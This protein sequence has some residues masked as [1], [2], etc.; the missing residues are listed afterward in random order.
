MFDENSRE[1]IAAVA[2]VKSHDASDGGV[3]E[4]VGES[5]SL[6]V[7]RVVSRYS[8]FISSQLPPANFI[9]IHY[10]YFIGLCLLASLIFWGSSTPARSISYHDSLFLAV[11]AMTLTGLNTVNLSQLN[12]FQQFIL[13]LLTLLGSAI[14]VSIAVVFV[15]MK[16][17]ERRFKTVVEEEKRRQKERGSLRRRLTLRSNRSNS[18]SKRPTDID[19]SNGELRSRHEKV[20][21]PVENE[22][23][24]KDLEI[25]RRASADA[26]QGHFYGP[27]A[28][29]PA[30]TIDT[31]A[32]TRR[33]ET[34]KED[35]YADLPDGI[36]R[37]RG[38]TFAPT[39]TSSKRIA[40]LAR[41]FSMQ[42]VGARHDLPNH[43]IRI[44][45]PDTFLSPVE[46]HQTTIQSAD[47]MHRFWIPGI[48]GRNSHFSNLSFA[49]RERLGGVEY[50][51]LELLIVVVPLYF[52]AWQFLGAIGMGAWVAN[53]GRDLTQ[54]N[55]L[56]PWWVGAFNAVSGF[57]NSGMMLLDAN[58]V[59]F[60]TSRYMLITV[61]LLIL[62]GN[63]CYP[64]FLRLIL[65]TIWSL[66]RFLPETPKVVEYR[67]TLRFLLDHPRRCY[68]NLFPARHTWWLLATL[69]GLNGIDWA[70]FE[71][72]NIGNKAINTNVSAGTRALE[73]LFQALAVRSGGFYVVT[74][75]SL[76]AGLLV[77]YVIMMY[78][79]VY[80]V[81]IS[82]RN[83]N[84][85]E[86]RSLGIYSEE[87]ANPAGNAE[88]AEPP[89][90]ISKKEAVIQGL[91]RR[92]TVQLGAA[93]NSASKPAISET[94]GYFVRQQL[95]GQLAHDLWWVVLAV[96]FIT[97]TET[98][99]YER[100]PVT[101]SVFNIIF[102]VISAYGCVGL[103]V[104]VP[105]AAYSFA[106]D[107]HVLS[108][109]IL[110]AV[111]LRGRHRGLPVA[112]DRAV[113][114]PGDHLTAAEEED[115]L[116]RAEKSQAKAAVNE[117]M[118]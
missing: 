18:V 99:S 27:P 28:K 42:G 57:N 75:S 76:R 13:F 51:T 115:A 85:Y 31:S 110:C 7:P 72:L 23:D 101:F 107:W 3:A 79:S 66:L 41:L 56:D 118:V 16:A 69:V 114:L 4:Q 84:V 95:R 103:S 86:E 74:I 30:L 45:R 78:I 112:I 108:K 88:Q 53:N 22:K 10:A 80:P 60:Q 11:S 105:T 71:V 111:M 2:A 89:T 52:V 6:K 24:I 83:S 38:V 43:P 32:D 54:A 17:F 113:L 64:V 117:K 82:I 59:A 87:P 61:G 14:T 36:R 40:P 81:V 96:L 35:D 55:G 15:R 19:P 21:D 50:R 34:G 67:V 104:G 90:P 68:T 62:A 39:P 116:I 106:G 9:T 46:D 100:D 8:A 91:K 48:V 20:A 12:T 73:G 65:W 102:E 63:T 92:M 58:M 97:I 49:D 44:S 25:G 94:R 1:C 5:W 33:S 70:A 98:S 109:L 37:K 47:L 93:A 29:P 26:T 77:L